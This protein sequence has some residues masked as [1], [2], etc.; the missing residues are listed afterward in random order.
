[1]PSDPLDELR[2]EVL[3]LRDWRHDEAIPALVA[4]REQGKYVAAQ[5][6]A[7]DVRLAHLEHQLQ[8]MARADEIAE[9]IQQHSRG[10][11]RGFLNAWERSL[12]VTAAVVGAVGVIL[13]ILRV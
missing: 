12:I 11:R 2:D 1:V 6:D 3:R 4:A 5:L 13:Q 8:D 9:A 7:I 10:F